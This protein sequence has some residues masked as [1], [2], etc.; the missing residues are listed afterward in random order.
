MYVPWGAATARQGRVSEREIQIRIVLSHFPSPHFYFT[1][2]S[3][4]QDFLL[5]PLSCIVLYCLVFRHTQPKGWIA[6]VAGCISHSVY[7]FISFSIARDA[8]GPIDDAGLCAALRRIWAPSIDGKLGGGTGVR[9]SH[10][11]YML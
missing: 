4:V 10:R 11:I 2:Y 1:M 7:K 6:K 5:F 9:L 3:N 8:S